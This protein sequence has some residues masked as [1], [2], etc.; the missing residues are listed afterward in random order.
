MLGL[1]DDRLDLAVVDDLAHHAHVQLD[2]ECQTV[3]ELGDRVGHGHAVGRHGH[4]DG[5]VDEIGYHGVAAALVLG[6]IGDSTDDAH[7]LLLLGIDVEVD[8]GVVPCVLDLVLEHLLEVVG[9]HVLVTADGAV[10]VGFG[11]PD[12]EVDIA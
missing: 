12:V 3:G 4:R 2:A 5:D 9:D 11:Q 10:H 7:V 8:G 6:M 1:V